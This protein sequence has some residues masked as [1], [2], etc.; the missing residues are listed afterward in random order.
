MGIFDIFRKK[1]LEEVVDEEYSVPEVP[2]C[3]HEIVTEESESIPEVETP[4]SNLDAVPNRKR[5]LKDFFEIDILKLKSDEGETR[6]VLEEPLMGMFYY[7]EFHNLSD[8]SV[9]L[10]FLSHGK[11]FSKEVIDFVESC[12]K[13]F[14]PTQQGETVITPRDQQL[15]LRGVFS[16]MWKKIWL[17]CSTDSDTGLK[18]LCLTIFNVDE[19]ANYVMNS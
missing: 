18:A 3:G 16:R 8:G 17:E 11:R 6:I 9:N 4:K 19:T 13:T 10:E 2:T 5:L 7:V 14:G 12:A 1:K 15:L